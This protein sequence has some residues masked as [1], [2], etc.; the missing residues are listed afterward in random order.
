M[1]EAILVGLIVFAA[2]LYAV[3][4][5]LP[6]AVRLRA[7]RQFADWTG[8]PGRPAWLR[9]VSASVETAARRGAGACSDCGAVQSS[10]TAPSRHERPRD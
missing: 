9:R 4:R 2:A 10:P 6:T 7:A 3:W 1:W 8:R 5:L